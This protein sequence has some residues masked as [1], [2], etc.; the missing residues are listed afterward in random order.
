[1]THLM[2][3]AVVEAGVL[4]RMNLETTGTPRVS[5]LSVCLSVHLSVCLSACLSVCLTFFYLPIYPPF[6]ILH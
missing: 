5:T 1:M 2:T 6:P 4:A 3:G